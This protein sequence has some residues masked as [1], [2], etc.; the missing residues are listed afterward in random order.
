M[1]LSKSQLAKRILVRMNQ[2]D[3]DEN[4]EIK[5]DQD[6]QE[7]MD[8]VY[9]E[10]KDRGFI[11]WDLEGMPSQ[12]Q[13]AFINIVADRAAPDFGASTQ[14]LQMRAQQGRRTILALS[15]RK[16]DT[17]ESEPTDY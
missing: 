5:E 11:G 12:Y 6:I 9:L 7:V 4:P 16:I 13:D 14:E 2:L 15:A 10:Y 8:S 3:P 17:R 1:P